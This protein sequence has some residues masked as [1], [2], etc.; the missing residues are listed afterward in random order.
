M[1][2]CLFALLCKEDV[3]K[4]N[5]F[6]DC[7]RR[8][9]LY[10][11]A[12]RARSPD[13]PRILLCQRNDKSHFADLLCTHRLKAAIRAPSRTVTTGNLSSVWTK[14]SLLGHSRNARG[15]VIW[16]PDEYLHQMR[17][18]CP[19]SR[20]APWQSVLLVGRKTPFQATP[21]MP[22][23]QSFASRMNICIRRD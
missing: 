12:I 17:H 1:L 15:T 18:S 16:V 19:V 5:R 2:M 22:D 13:N 9:V 7:H 10:S 21:G 20:R 23:G 3:K 6:C 14:K 11:R 4:D 8:L